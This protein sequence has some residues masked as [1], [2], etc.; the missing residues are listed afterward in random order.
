MGVSIQGFAWSSWRASTIGSFFLHA[1]ELECGTL[2][3]P[4][5]IG[6]R[7]TQ[8]G[9]E[10]RFLAGR[11]KGAVNFFLRDVY[12]SSAEIVVARAL[13]LYLV[14]EGLSHSRQKAKTASGRVETRRDAK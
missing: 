13:L 12:G 7:A 6:G 2:P 3:L 9:I 10:G 5:P 11:L 8:A 14:T 1:V 4:R